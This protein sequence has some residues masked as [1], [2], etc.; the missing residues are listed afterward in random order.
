MAKWRRVVGIVVG[1]FMLLSAA[2]HSLMGGKLLRA[3][4]QAAGVPDD[5]LRGVLVG[6]H[7]GGAAMVAFGAVVLLTFAR[8]A[9]S[10]EPSLGP[11]RVIALLYLAFGVGALAVSELD[12][13]FLIFLVPGLLLAFAAFPRLRP[14]GA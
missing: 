14:R 10:G 1:S 9:R 7:F 11:A 6:W 5:L 8:H 3:D 13:F 4:L 2:A 12:P